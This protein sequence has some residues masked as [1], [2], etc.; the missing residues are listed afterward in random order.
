MIFYSQTT[1]VK[2]FIIKMQPLEPE[3]KSTL[4]ILPVFI[5]TDLAKHHQNHPEQYATNEENLLHGKISM[6]PQYCIEYCIYMHQCTSK[7]V[8]YSKGQQNSLL[9]L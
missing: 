1:K 6:L 8:S 5:P 4:V 3:E 7:M 9:V 2:N